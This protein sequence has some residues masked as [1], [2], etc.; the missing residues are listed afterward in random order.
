[1]SYFIISHHHKELKRIAI[2]IVL[3]F[4]DIEIKAKNNFLN[5]FSS[6]EDGGINFSLKIF[7]TLNFYEILYE[8]MKKNFI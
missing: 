5:T 6:H 1:M 8:E 3:D 7:I 2:V 4:Q